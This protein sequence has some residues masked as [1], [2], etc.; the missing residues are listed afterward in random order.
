MLIDAHTH[1]LSTEIAAARA[2]YC[3]RDRWFGQCYGHPQARFATVES[4][5]ASL[6]GAGLDRA[7][8]TGFA[9]ADGGLCRASNDYLLE[10]VSRYPDRLIG[11]AA[12]QP[13][14]GERAVYEAERCLKGGLAGLG[15][16]LPDGQG[17]DPT[18]TILLTPLARFLIEQDRPVMLHTSEPTGHQYG[19]KGQTWPQKIVELAQNFPALKIIAAHW[20]GGLPFYE[21][22]P[23]VRS[24]LQNVWYDTAA[25]T[26][27][28][29]FKVFRTV[30]DLCGPAKILF[31]SDYP[32]LKQGR[33]LSRVRAES[34]LTPTELE[35]VMGQNAARLFGLSEAGL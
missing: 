30:A 33:L 26:Y 6:D 32:L 18:D 35:A 16:L 25:T 22:M 20:G 14:D 29:D 5:I 10:A 27:L 13:R 34:G 19:G 7:V 1:I 4:L 12:V 24:T 11:L 3:E 2:H 8:V 15:E 31:A 28:Y 17:F 23:E 21:L 9:F